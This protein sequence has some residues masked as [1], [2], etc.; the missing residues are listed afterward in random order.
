MS[1][2]SALDAGAHIRLLHEFAAAKI[3]AA[4]HVGK[5]QMDDPR[6]ATTESNGPSTSRKTEVSGRQGGGGNR[7]ERPER[8]ACGPALA[9][10]TRFPAGTVKLG[11]ISARV[12]GGTGPIR[13]RAASLVR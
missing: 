5:E 12:T 11:S 8:T 1:S 2:C 10:N 6:T 3:L 7:S 4:A 9:A 13:F